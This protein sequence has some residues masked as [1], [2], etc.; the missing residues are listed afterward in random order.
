MPLSKELKEILACPVCLVPVTAIGGDTELECRACGRRYPV[1]E[2]FPVM[3]P[4]EA[5]PPT[6]EVVSRHER[7]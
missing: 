7:R 1:R 4:E 3:I 2:G 5:T 6:R